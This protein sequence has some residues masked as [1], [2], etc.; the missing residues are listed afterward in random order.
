[1]SQN[2]LADRSGLHPSAVSHFAN[3]TRAPSFDNLCRLSDALGVTTDYLV[4][5]AEDAATHSAIGAT[6]G[7]V[8][9]AQ[10]TT[11]QRDMVDDFVQMLLSRSEQKSSEHKP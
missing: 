9:Y 6:Y 3:G 5:R 1:M 10:L 4:G 8:H 2:E 11:D 7:S